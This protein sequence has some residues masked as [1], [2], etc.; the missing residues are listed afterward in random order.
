MTRSTIVAAALVCITAFQAAEYLPARRL[1]GDVPQ[2]AFNAV[3]WIE[4]TVDIELSDTGAVVKT[5]TLRATPGGADFVLPSLRTWTF[6]PATDD[7]GTPVASHVLVAALIRPAQLFDPAGG[8]PAVDLHAPDAGVVFPKSM[9]RPSYPV[10][11]IGDR[12]V[13]VE[14][15]V[16]AEGRVEDATVVGA[17]SGFDSAALT[18]ARGWTFRPARDKDKAV[19]GTAYLIFGFRTPTG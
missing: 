11:A 8:S 3:G 17:A 13:L 7:E 14:V 15:T 5:T 9:T 10:N 2:P 16:S 19:P 12:S 18:A 4:A 6:K 1:S